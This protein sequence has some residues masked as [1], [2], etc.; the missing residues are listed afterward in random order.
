MTELSKE[1]LGW[2]VKL[3]QEAK[4]R[5]FNNYLDK[6]EFETGNAEEIAEVKDIQ[7]QIDNYYEG[8]E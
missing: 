4:K 3:D 8:V 2:Y 6:R 7:K 5:G 1:A